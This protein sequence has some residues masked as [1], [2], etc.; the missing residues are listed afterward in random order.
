M[1]WSDSQ[2]KSKLLSF[3]VG[4]QT[5]TLCSVAAA[6]GVSVTDWP[7]CASSSFTWTPPPAGTEQKVRQTVAEVEDVPSETSSCSEMNESGWS[8]ST[9]EMYSVGPEEQVFVHARFTNH[10][11]QLHTVWN[12]TA[13]VL[14]THTRTHKFHE[15]VIIRTGYLKEMHYCLPE[16]KQD[17][18]Y[19]YYTVITW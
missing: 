17:S 18:V 14:H 11:L 12:G 7:P 5:L 13:Q 15:C 9:C 8:Q 16:I 6:A 1:T 4:F 3:W 19:C 2:S 10:L